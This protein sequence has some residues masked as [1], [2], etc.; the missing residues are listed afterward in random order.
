[1]S[2]RLGRNPFGTHA[3]APVPAPSTSVPATEATFAPKPK[4]KHKSE[5]K[6]ELEPELSSL[7]DLFLK[8]IP[9]AALMLAIKGA[10]R[11]LEPSPSDL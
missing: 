8:D 5:P 11:L 9:A 2:S 1:M 4:P 3:P 7:S 10:H 6:P